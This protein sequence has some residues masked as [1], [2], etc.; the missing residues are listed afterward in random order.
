MNAGTDYTK[1]RKHAQANADRTQS[2]RWLHNYNGHY[3]ISRS[4]T[5][6]AE[7]I[8]PRTLRVFD[9]YWAPEGRIIAT[10]DAFDATSAK[11]QTPAPYRRYP[12]EVYVTER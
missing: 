8:D 2:P 1:A 6:D 11:Q 3:W 10:V 5:A 12:G 7:R 9:I 4:H